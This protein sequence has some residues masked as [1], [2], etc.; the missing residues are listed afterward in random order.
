M[1]GRVGLG[2]VEAP[3]SARGRWL[4][5]A[6]PGVQ[7]FGLENVTGLDVSEEEVTSTGGSDRGNH[8]SPPSP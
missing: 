1:C 8:L 7:A 4:L 2:S 5:A 3:E 6:P